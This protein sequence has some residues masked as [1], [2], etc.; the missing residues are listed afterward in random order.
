MKKRRSFSVYAHLNVRTSITIAAESLEDAL[1][2]A[3][4][5]G[6]GDFAELV[7][8]YDDGDVTIKG[9]DEL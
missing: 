2:Q 8:S 6:L 4:S 9:V 7:G 3:R 5:F 1:T